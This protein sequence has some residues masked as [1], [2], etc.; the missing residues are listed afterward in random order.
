MWVRSDGLVSIE[1]HDSSD[2]GFHLAGPIA[3]SNPALSFHV[4][5]NLSLFRAF[6]TSFPRSTLVCGLAVLLCELLLSLN[7]QC[8]DMQVRPFYAELDLPSSSLE[9]KIA[10]I[11]RTAS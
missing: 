4:P 6:P 7:L 9:S 3:G 10:W 8:R 11:K 2:S 1:N 5:C